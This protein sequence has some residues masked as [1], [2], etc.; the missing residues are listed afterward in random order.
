MTPNHRKTYG[1]MLL[2]D[3]LAYLG[4]QVSGVIKSQNM[5]IMVDGYNCNGRYVHGSHLGGSCVRI[6]GTIE[7]AT[8]WWYRLEQRWQFFDQLGSADSGGCCL[9]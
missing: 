3:G 4:F 5:V 9:S 2:R 7:R 6:P 8:I 1:A